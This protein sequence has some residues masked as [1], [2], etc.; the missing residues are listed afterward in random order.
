MYSET[1]GGN[2]GN[3]DAVT[4]TKY[5]PAILIASLRSNGPINL[6]KELPDKFNFLF[7]LAILRQ[8]RN[9]LGFKIYTYIGLL[10]GF[11]KY[12]RPDRT[13]R[14]LT[15]RNSIVFVFLCLCAASYTSENLALYAVVS[16]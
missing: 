15:V 7:W 5:H 16:H 14:E 3:R 10:A 8:R 12:I 4:N 11:Q 9:A 2:E 13:V 6:C 1:T